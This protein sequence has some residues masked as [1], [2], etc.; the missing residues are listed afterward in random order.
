MPNPAN[1]PIIAVDIDDVIYPLVPSLIE[2]L[3]TEHKVR[4]TEEDFLEYDLRK[5]WSGGPVEAAKIFEHYKESSGV[6]IA[7]L[8]DAQ[9]ALHTLSKKYDIIVMTSRDIS[10]FPRTH[11]WITHHFPD[12]FKDV[13]LLGNRSDSQTFRPKAEV[14][15]ELGV[16]CLI[17]DNL[18]H[19]VET[20]QAGIRVILFG[21][22]PWNQ[23]NELPKGVTRVKD[24]QGVLKELDG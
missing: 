14:C 23:T 7:P 18:K 24:W 1:K 6:Q 16:Y 15:V 4:L 22:Y 10:T 13:Q 5:V 2:Y 8:E 17:D 21:D 3:D 9:K 19:A 20:Y 11:N 12:I